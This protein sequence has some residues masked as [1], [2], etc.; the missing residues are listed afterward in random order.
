MLKNK[1]Y[2][3]EIFFFI[4][5]TL[6]INFNFN[7]D[8]LGYIHLKLH[9]FLFLTVL[10]SVRYGLM[11]GTLSGV[12]TA[13]TFIFFVYY[14]S[15]TKVLRL[16]FE[17]NTYFLP[18]IFIITGSF[19]GE[20]REKYIQKFKFILN[21]KIKLED[22]YK[23]LLENIRLLEMTNK[24]LEKR[25]MGNFSTFS[26][27]YEAS[28]GLDTLDIKEL[29]KSIFEILSNYL[30]F[31]EFSI[32]LK[33]NNKYELFNYKSEFELP[34]K[35]DYDSFSGL[36]NEVKAKFKKIRPKTMGQALRIDGITPAAVYILLSH[37]KRKSIKHIA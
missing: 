37:L 33:K 6:I 19:I 34:E 16:L 20:I 29:N 13:L 3:F 21:S 26:V 35:L 5:I 18:M 27:L 30:K 14:Q 4:L 1:I 15:S 31:E 8:D 2:I 36:S 25:I 17:F 9:P 32:Y 7:P 28:Q 10:I 12:I 22:D 24:S 11:P 23:N